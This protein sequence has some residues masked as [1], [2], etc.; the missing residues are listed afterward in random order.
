MEKSVLVLVLKLLG[1]SLN[2]RLPDGFTIEPITKAPVSAV[3]NCTLLK[4]GLHLMYIR[5][6]LIV[7]VTRKLESMYHH[8][9]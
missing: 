3:C 6:L 4:A 8:S 9:Q 7:C 1:S 2:Y 5:I